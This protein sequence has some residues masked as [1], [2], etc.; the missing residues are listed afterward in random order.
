MVRDRNSFNYASFYLDYTEKNRDDHAGT[1]T[2]NFRTSGAVSWLRPADSG[3]STTF[4]SPGSAMMG[5]GK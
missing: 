5:Q 3:P 1:E 2:G 4:G